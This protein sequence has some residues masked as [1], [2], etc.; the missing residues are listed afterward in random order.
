MALYSRRAFER[1][2]NRLPENKC[3][4]RLGKAVNPISWIYG[5]LGSTGPISGQ[6]GMFYFQKMY[7]FEKT[8]SSKHT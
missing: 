1:L 7:L 4:L 3:L 8:L 6:I 5:G 2:P